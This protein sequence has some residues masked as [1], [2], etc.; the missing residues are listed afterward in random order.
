MLCGCSWAYG[1]SQRLKDLRKA[2]ISAEELGLLTEILKAVYGRSVFC[3]CAQAA[4]KQKVIQYAA[5]ELLI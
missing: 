1:E 2:W 4:Q 5:C 3:F